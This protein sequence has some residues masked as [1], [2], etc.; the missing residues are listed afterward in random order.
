MAILAETSQRTRQSKQSAPRQLWVGIVLVVMAWISSWFGPDRAREIAFIPL[1]LGYILT[2]DGIVFIRQGSSLLSR[3]RREFALLFLV[4]APLW[5]VF[6]LANIRLDNWRYIHPYHY[7]WLHSHVFATLAFST[8]LP[9]VFET[10]DL[11]STTR[12]RRWGKEWIRWNPS[13]NGLLIISAAGVMIFAGSLIIPELLFPFTWI[14][15]FFAFDPI[16]RLRGYPSM[17]GRVANGDW[18]PV[19]VFFVAGL[20]CGIF[21]EMWNFYSMPKWVYSVPYASRP[22]IF[23]MPLLGFGGY[24]PFALELYAAYHLIRS[25]ILGPIP[26]RL[27]IDRDLP[28]IDEKDP[29]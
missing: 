28:E 24:F 2:V 23:E 21:W 12:V 6:E 18:S 15:L 29:S 13:R 25:F 19:I 27:L 16:N 9:A 10:S 4:S 1:W 20:I 17:S 26:S 22:K 11:I 14:G 3:N 7:S 8:V 5:W